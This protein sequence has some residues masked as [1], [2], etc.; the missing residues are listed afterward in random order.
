MATQRVFM[1]AF[2]DPD[3]EPRTAKYTMGN[4]GRS[5]A[6]DEMALFSR[7]ITDKSVLRVLVVGFVLVLFATLAAG[8]VGIRSLISIQDNAGTLVSELRLASNLVMQIQRQLTGVSAV[9]R[10]LSKDP[11]AIDAGEVRLLIDEAERN[12]ARVSRT[13]QRTAEGH[14]WRELEAASK[15][16]SDEARHCLDLDDVPIAAT[17]TLF[18]HHQELISTVAGLINL[19]Y[20]RAVQ[21]QAQIDRQSQRFAR[22]TAYIAGG[23]LLVALVFAILTLRMAAGLI[24][25]MEA[26]ANEL[27]R[28]SWQ[29]L[30]SQ[31]STVRRFSHEL[32]DE[33]GQSLTAV[34]ANLTALKSPKTMD[35]ARLDDSLALVDEAIQNVRE[36]SHLLHPRVLDDFGL[37]A[38]LRS[39]GE[40]LAQRTALTIDY[41]SNLE[42]RL[43]LD[44]AT[45]IFRIAQ[46]ALTNVVKHSE[47]TEAKVRL[48]RNNGEVALSIQ[49][50][51]RGFP[52]DKKGKGLGLVAMAARARQLGGELKL[53]T[54]N[55]KGASVEIRIPV[56][57][58]YHDE[59]DSDTSGR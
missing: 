37:D 17:K 2:L 25:R 9:T 47:A 50:N 14:L 18:E 41:E 26:Q 13:G 40:R 36:M 49:D 1:A 35:P 45:H 44:T 48:W 39:L 11:E 31:E 16:F 19:S 28:I 59:K 8:L 15:A 21:A 34:K 20:R 43:P 4:G 56:Q 10:R 12:I 51:G 5:A 58:E 3:A 23:C 38:A 32:H 6:A 52:S 46:E 54:A 27:S 24:R 57:G 7:R 53:G 42:R 22:E 33:L 29:L 30:E 55:G